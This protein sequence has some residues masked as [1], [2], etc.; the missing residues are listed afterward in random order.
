[1][2]G[3]THLRALVTLELRRL[4]TGGAGALREDDSAM[5]SVLFRLV[6]VVLK[7]EEGEGGEK[8]GRLVE[9]DGC[10]VNIGWTSCIVVP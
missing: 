4:L 7:E 8:K 6:M 2:P 5:V 3:R 9:K 1:M 10:Q